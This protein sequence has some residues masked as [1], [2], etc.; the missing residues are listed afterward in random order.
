LQYRDSARLDA[1]LPLALGAATI[2]EEP[3]VPSPLI[4]D[5]VR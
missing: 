5:E 1:A 2:G 4:L 3:P